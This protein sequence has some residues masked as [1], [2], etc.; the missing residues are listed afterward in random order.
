MSVCL[1]QQ[2]IQNHCFFVLW[3]FL[4]CIKCYLVAFK[5]LIKASSDISLRKCLILLM[6]EKFLIGMSSQLFLLRSFGKSIKFSTFAECYWHE[7]STTPARQASPGM[8][9]P[10]WAEIASKKSLSPD[11][12]EAQ[13]G[14]GESGRCSRCCELIEVNHWSYNNP[15]EW[16]WKAGFKR[17]SLV[18]TGTRLTLG[19]TGMC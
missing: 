16:L 10:C 17:G 6:R 19:D 9:L 12:W 1:D 7:S 5:G 18:K 11:H 3:W 15:W 8:P 4:P 2:Y 14:D 13:H